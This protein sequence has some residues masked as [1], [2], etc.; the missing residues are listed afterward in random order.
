MSRVAKLQLPF[1]R[2]PGED[3]RRWENAFRKGDIFDDDRGGAHLSDRREKHCAQ[4]MRSTSAFSQIAIRACCR[5]CL[6]RG[7]SENY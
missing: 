5:S 6:R 2:W 4:A 7:S 1:E 3:R